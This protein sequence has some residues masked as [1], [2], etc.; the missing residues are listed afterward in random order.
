MKTAAPHTSLRFLLMIGCVLATSAGAQWTAYNDCIY[1]TG[2]YIAPNVT[3]YGV[4]ERYTG[5]TSGELINQADGTG[6]GVTV[7]L[8][9]SGGVSWQPTPRYGGSDCAEGTDAHDT[10]GNLVDMTGVLTY[11][12]EGWIVEITFTG[13][14]PGARYTFATSAARNDYTGRLTIYTII[15]ADT[16]TNASTPGVDVLGEDRVRFDTGG[17]HNEGYVARWTNIT[18]QD[19][20]FTVRAE[21]DPSSPGGRKAYS[22]DVFM[23]RRDADPEPA[24]DLN[25]DDRVDIADLLIFGGIWLTNPGI[26][27]D[28]NDD[29]RVDM[30]DLGIIAVNWLLD[31]QAGALQVNITPPDAVAAGAQWSPDGRNWYDSGQTVPDLPVGP[32]TVQFRDIAGW[33]E[34]NDLPVEVAYNDTTVVDAQYVLQAGTVQVMLEPAEARDA[35]AQWSL[36]GVTWYESGHTTDPLPVGSYTVMFG[37]VDGWITP[38]ETPITIADGQATLVTGTY[39][40]RTGNL[41]VTINPPDVRAQARWSIDGTTWYESGQTVENLPV[42]TYTVQ[43]APVEGWDAPAAQDV[44]VLYAQ[45]SLLYADYARQYGQLTV[46]IEPPDVRNQARWS[47]DGQTWHEHGHT[48][49]AIPVGTYTLEFNTVAGYTAPAP[50]SVTITDG[51][52]TAETGTR[53]SASL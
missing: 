45:T 5:P 2:Q 39:E 13:L 53:H 17:N 1:D 8:T 20:T 38:Q 46:S 9:Q 41:I 16:Y 34:P 19:G 43:F 6:T 25:N 15:G 28:L 52:T 36:D 12:A 27:G 29:G 40:R 30:G 50:R 44:T 3:T 35:G 10:F 49:D 47:I 18:A 26:P 48:L 14:E 32:Y 11:G 21:A 24:G 37:A 22:F 33:N 4:G 23:L 42:G 7:T 31:W 51:T